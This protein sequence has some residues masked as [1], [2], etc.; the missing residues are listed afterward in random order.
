MSGGHWNYCG[1]RIR[2]DLENV[3][4]DEIVVARWPKLG[5]VLER[6]AVALHDVE[7]EMDWDISC[8]SL[9]K[10]DAAFQRDAILKLAAALGS[11][12]ETHTP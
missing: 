9:I 11:A 2:D 4:T 3:A 1:V 6:L 12:Q 8:D 7:R 5:A 10:D